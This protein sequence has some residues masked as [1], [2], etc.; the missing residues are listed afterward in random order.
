LEIDLNGNST[1]P[2]VGHVNRDAITVEQIQD[3]FQQSTRQS[4]VMKQ[5]LSTSDDSRFAEGR[6]SHRLSLVK[7]RILKR[8]QPNQ[9]IQK[10][11]G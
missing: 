10:R 9:T 3:L 5:I 7:L 6:K 11:I 1:E 4:D 2:M 8:G